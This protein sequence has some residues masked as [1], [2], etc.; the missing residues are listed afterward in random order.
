MAFYRCVSKGRCSHLVWGR[1]RYMSYA[2]I[3][4]NPLKCIFCA[5]DFLAG[6]RNQAGSSIYLGPGFPPLLPSSQEGS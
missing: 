2:D 6:S 3:K 5:C 1:E 4:G